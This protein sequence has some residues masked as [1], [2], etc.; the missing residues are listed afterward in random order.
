MQEVVSSTLI[1][2]IRLREVSKDENHRREKRGVSFCAFA[3]EGPQ[4]NSSVRLMICRGDVE[5]VQRAEGAHDPHLG[6]NDVFL[7][8]EGIGKRPG[9]ARG[10]VPI[11]G[12]A[13]MPHRDH[14]AV[15]VAESR[16][17]FHAA[18]G[19]T[20]VLNLSYD[21]NTP[22]FVLDRPEIEDGKA[23]LSQ[24][25]MMGRSDVG[26]LSAGRLTIL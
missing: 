4:R 14:S 16:L 15:G 2:S 25:R 7:S 3:R 20:D 8:P 10:Y 24:V 12:R 23:I 5:D 21:R 17:E 6:M 19:R 26:I 13:E 1:G 18:R 9:F 22:E 11:G